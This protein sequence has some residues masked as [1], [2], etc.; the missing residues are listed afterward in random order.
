MNQNPVVVLEEVTFRWPRQAAPALVVSSLRVAPGERLFIRGASGSG[1]TTLL[2]LVA[3]LLLPDRGSVT[4]LG[5][6]LAALGRGGRDQF[7][8]DHIGYI[9]QLFNLVPYLSVI[10]NVLLPCR[11][12]RRRREKAAPGRRI[13]GASAEAERLLRRLQLAESTLGRARVT[14]LSTG[15]QQ[16]VAVA[17]ALIGRPELI[18]ADEP[19]SALDQDARNSFLDLL[20]EECAAAGTSLL[21]VSHDGTLAPRFHRSMD[22]STGICET[23]SC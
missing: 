14:A 9:F 12:S 22:L 19:T 10:D 23:A 13:G 17:R 11:F 16:R 15:E 8:A 5:Q 20:F 6:D 18:I 1:K 7:R 3:G 2:S 21:F 4:V